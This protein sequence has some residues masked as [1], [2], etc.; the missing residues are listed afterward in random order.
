M[1][2]IIIDNNTKSIYADSQGTCTDWR[3]SGIVFQN[4][5]FETTT[6]Q[7]NTEKV[8]YISKE[9]GWITGTGN[10]HLVHECVGLSSQNNKFTLPNISKGYK[11]VTIINVVVDPEGKIDVM[12]YE[13]RTKVKHK[14]FHK[15]FWKDKWQRLGDDGALFYG[16]G[17][18]YA[19]GAYKVCND[20]VE[21]IV[22]ASKCDMYTNSH[23]KVHKI[24][25]TEDV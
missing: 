17:S 8:F 7:H 18:D 15:H 13:P 20:P 24:Y 9:V 4:K 25:D 12:E 3:N 5:D 14:L 16:S 10:L 1:T 6:L 11:N 23:V 22:A 2:T 19:L 21:S